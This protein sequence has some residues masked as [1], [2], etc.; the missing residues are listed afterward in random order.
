[1]CRQ[2]RD[3]DLLNCFNI[4]LYRD[5]LCK[6]GNKMQNDHGT[7]N[8]RFAHTPAIRTEAKFPFYC[9]LLLANSCGRDGSC[10]PSVEAILGL[11]LEFL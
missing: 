3:M 4:D 9:R 8:S 10:T 11:G 2:G 5:A 7:V 1:M 6:I